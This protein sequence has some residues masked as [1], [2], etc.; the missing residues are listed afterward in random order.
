MHKKSTFVFKQ[1]E[2]LT[3]FKPLDF[4]RYEELAEEL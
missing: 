4:G 1:S 2:D 3:V